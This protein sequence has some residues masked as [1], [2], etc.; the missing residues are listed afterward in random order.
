MKL[1]DA[2][3]IIAAAIILLLGVL[4]GLHAQ[5]NLAAYQAA[6]DSILAAPA[7]AKNDSIKAI[8][9][10]DSIRAAFAAQKETWEHRD[11]TS[12]DHRTL[13]SLDALICVLN[14]VWLRRERYNDARN[15]PDR[16]AALKFYYAKSVISASEAEIMALNLQKQK[17]LEQQGTQYLIEHQAGKERLAAAAHL[18]K[19]QAELSQISD[20]LLSINYQPPRIEQGK[21]AE[22]K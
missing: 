14:R 5:D 9:E 22:I 16:I 21:K 19:V 1:I 15:I 11:L 8:H 18:K 2:N 20:Y 4:A 10:S 13:D 12:A 3:K 6:T 7:Q 17:T